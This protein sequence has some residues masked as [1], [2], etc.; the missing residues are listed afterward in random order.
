M[1][2]KCYPLTG[3]RYATAA[4][5]FVGVACVALIM[6]SSCSTSSKSDDEEIAT[7]SVAIARGHEL[8]FRDCSSCHGFRQDGIGPQLAG[9]TREVS[10][11][12]LRGFIRNPGAMIDSGD[13]RAQV[14]LAS[15]KTIMPAFPHYTDEDLNDIIAFLNTRNER[16]APARPAHPDALTDPIPEKIPMSD[17]VVGLRQIAEIPP[18]AEPPLRTRIAKLDYR[19]DSKELF[20]LDL[21]GQLYRLG[22]EGPELY[23]D[24]AAL[25]P[26]F[27]DTP[28][29][30][31]GFGSFAFHPEFAQ[32]GLLYTTHTEGPDSATPD[33]SYSD[34]IKVML[35]WVLTE[36]K[37]ESPSGVPFEGK[38]RELLRVNMVHSFHGVQEITFNPLAK[39]GDEDYGLL[40]IGIGDGASVEFGYPELVHS[41]SKI[42]GTII[43]IDPKGN[44]SANGK[45]GI[46]PGNPF[47]GQRN[48]LGEVYAYGFRNPHR[49]S[50]TKSGQILASNIGHHNIESLNLI[51]PG[52]NYGWPVREGTFVMDIQT[53]L[54]EVF[55]LPSDDETYGITYPVAQYDHDEGNAIS[56]GYEYW[57][58]KVPALEG[59]CIFGDIVSG[60]L[61]YVDMKDIQLGRQAPIKEFRVSLNGEIKDLA[62]ICGNMRV[63][64]RFGRDA[65]GELY[66]FTKP[67]G[68]VYRIVQ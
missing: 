54:A 28:G 45:Y 41:P 10:A 32:N 52:H 6:L 25:R 5:S 67:D 30:A 27:I 26:A 8:F 19:P 9:V 38:G 15:Y 60:R 12:W 56:G 24:M 29:L 65:D 64:L 47:V 66:L 21:R 43:R 4:L 14:L 49:I 57:G 16:P 13:E 23:M 3:R 59:K 53:S 7:D 18:S 36:W 62:E 31:T 20:V 39:S 35:Q 40:Y 37:T 1:V 22:D 55:A 17:L 48:S 58:M 2:E 33:F 44:N 61:F 11:A 42:W 68:K 46:P 50:W 63:D 51:L 34:S